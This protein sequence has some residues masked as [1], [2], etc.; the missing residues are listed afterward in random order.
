MTYTINLNANGGICDTDFIDVTDYTEY[1]FEGWNSNIDGTGDTYYS[2]GKYSQDSNVI[3]F[4][5]YSSYSYDEETILPTPTRENHDFLGWATDPYATSGITGRYNPTDNVT[6]Y[7]IWKVR[8][9]V[10]ICD[11]L[12]GFSPYEVW[13]YDGSGWNQYVPYIYTESGWIEYSG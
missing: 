1:Y 5:Q 8:G 10:Y 13:I 3:L 2:G 7:A 11:K 12:G 6:L 9:Q 4:A